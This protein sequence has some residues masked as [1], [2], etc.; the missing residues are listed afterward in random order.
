MKKL[1]SVLILAILLSGGCARPTGTVPPPA[2][3]IDLT[4]AR[5]LLDAQT[6]IEQAKGLVAV[7]PIIKDTL[8]KVIASYNTVESA[9]LVYHKS[10]VAG[11]NPDPVAL[12][13]Q[14]AGLLTSVSELV[15]MLK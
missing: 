10:I 1:L 5:S 3:S 13:T 9:Y 12:Q 15:G 7:K 11:T 14:V 6:I 2:A 4:I 8:N